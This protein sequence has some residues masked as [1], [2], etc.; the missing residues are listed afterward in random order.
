MLHCAIQGNGDGCEKEKRRDSK[1]CF[2]ILLVLEVQ[3]EPLGLFD[4]DRR[5]ER[6]RS[7]RLGVTGTFRIGDMDRDT[8]LLLQESLCRHKDRLLIDRLLDE[9]L[10]DI[11]REAV[12]EST[13]GYE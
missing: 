9:G 3:T 13:G 6:Q 4:H 12:D 11:G 2:A 8:E 7:R 5:L 1:N 10:D